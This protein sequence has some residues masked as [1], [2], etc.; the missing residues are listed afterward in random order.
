MYVVWQCSPIQKY[1]Y[2]VD[3]GSF[4]I[5]N[6]LYYS[7]VEGVCQKNNIFVVWQCIAI[8]KYLYSVHVYLKD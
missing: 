6:S 2:S 8:Q 1:L 7:Q 5:S 4:N 3:V